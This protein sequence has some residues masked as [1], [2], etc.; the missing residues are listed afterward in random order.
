MMNETLC[1][2]NYLKRVRRDGKT[3]DVDLSSHPNWKQI[4]NNYPFIHDYC[5]PMDAL[6]I[7]VTEIETAFKVNYCCSLYFKDRDVHPFSYKKI[8]MTEAVCL[9]KRLQNSFQVEVALILKKKRKKRC[10]FTG[11]TEKI[12][13][14]HVPPYTFATIKRNFLK[15]FDE[16]TL[17]QSLVEE[18]NVGWRLPLI[19]RKKFHAY[20]RKVATLVPCT[21]KVNQ[22]RGKIMM[23]KKLYLEELI[24][25]TI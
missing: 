6:G 24:N 17:S 3:P 2:K 9:R 25:T 4:L 8:G 18:E 15:D 12:T 13:W 14:E 10:I 16:K 1:L 21:W 11:T 19:I 22:Y 20:H 5:N 23:W 7:C